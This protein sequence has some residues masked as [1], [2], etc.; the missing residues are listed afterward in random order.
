MDAGI[1]LPS[2]VRSNIDVEAY[3]GQPILQGNC[4]LVSVVEVKA[5][6]GDC[7]KRDIHILGGQR[8]DLDTCILGHIQKEL[9]E[10]GLLALPH[11]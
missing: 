8:Q 6:S 4:I 1:S 9:A 7:I 11:E 3:D 10:D 5:E 2:V